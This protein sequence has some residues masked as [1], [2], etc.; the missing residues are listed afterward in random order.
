MYIYIYKYIH[1]YIYIHIHI[2]IYI[3]TYI[4]IPIY[5]Y[6]NYIQSPTALLLNL[7]L[8]Y[9]EAWRVESNSFL[10]SYDVKQLL[11]SIP[12]GSHRNIVKVCHPLYMYL[13]TYVNAC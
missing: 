2:H 11:Y 4:N 10:N 7:C 13:R 5:N 1:I 12:K 9:V 6:I 3:Y 8:S